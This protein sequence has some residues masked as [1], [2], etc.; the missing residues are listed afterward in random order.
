LPPETI[1]DGTY[2]NK[3]SIGRF[4]GIVAGIAM[5]QKF[6]GTPGFLSGELTEEQGGGKKP[7]HAVGHRDINILSFSGFKKS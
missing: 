1:F 3:S 7:H 2:G 4:I 5:G 6:V